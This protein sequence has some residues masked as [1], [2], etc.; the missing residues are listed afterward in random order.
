[1][2][3]AFSLALPATV[4]LDFTCHYSTDTSTP[5]V[6]A[7]LTDPPGAHACSLYPVAIR[8][9]P[10]P[11]ERLLDKVRSS[12]ALPHHTVDQRIR[13]ST[14]R[15]VERR[16]RFGVS[17]LGQGDQVLVCQKEGRSPYN[18]TPAGSRY[19]PSSKGQP[20]TGRILPQLAGIVASCGSEGSRSLGP[21]ASS[22]YTP[23]PLRSTPCW[24]MANSPSLPD[25]S[26]G[27]PN[28]RP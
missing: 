7:T 28:V 26:L 21:A 23:L 8:Y 13:H 20:L 3:D 19:Y 18:K 25:T 17:V 1:M 12:L 10:R 6:L 16:E 22:S 2:P 5:R 11:T 24:T 15:V 27:T 14:M 9:S 4:S